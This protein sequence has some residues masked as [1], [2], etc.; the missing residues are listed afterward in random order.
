MYKCGNYVKP[1]TDDCSY[2]DDRCCYYCDK[3]WDCKAKAKCDVKVLME[4]NRFSNFKEG[5]EYRCIEHNGDMVLIDENKR[6]YRT[7]M[8][9]FNEDF[10]LIR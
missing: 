9:T 6:G 5:K 3:K 10:D 2:K 7:D 1:E 4:D 8:E